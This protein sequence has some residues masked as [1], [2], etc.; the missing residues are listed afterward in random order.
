MRRAVTT[1]AVVMIGFGLTACGGAQTP[2]QALPATTTAASKT[3]T[4]TERTTTTSPTSAESLADTDPCELLTSADKSAL[5]VTKFEG[6]E[7]LGTARICRIRTP[8]GT[9]TPGIR[10]NIGLTQVVVT[11]PINDLTIGSHKAK[12]LRDTATRGCIVFIG[13]TASSRVDVDAGDRQGDQD[14]ACDLALRAATLI[15]PNLPES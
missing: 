2:G 6:P 8:A 4:T 7:Q 12:Q 1:A 13:V 11:G 10:T 14:E 5:G 3:G 15:E 9:L